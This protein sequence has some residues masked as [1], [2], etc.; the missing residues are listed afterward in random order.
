MRYKIKAGDMVV[1]QFGRYPEL[2]QTLHVP[3]NGRVSLKG[4]GEFKVA[5]L[6]A[7]AFEAVL[8]EKYGAWLSRPRIRVQVVPAARFSI[9]V[10][11]EVLRPGRLPYAG[12]LTVARAILLAGG[13]K[14]N[15]SGKYEVTIFRNQG[16]EGIKM[17]KLKLQH[18]A[19]KW[20]K[21]KN[22]E[23]NPYDV[24]FVKKIFKKKS[25]NGRLI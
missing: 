10:G 18:V 7:K 14:N 19:S 1:V 5:E 17:F 11:G 8:K 20:G 21:N 4:V 6:T 22:F 23:L 9:Y 24:I 3:S 2:N 15:N 16:P 13:V 12:K 25:I